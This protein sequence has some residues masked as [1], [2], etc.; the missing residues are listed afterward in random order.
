MMASRT[1]QVG[2]WTDPPG[3]VSSG[4]RGRSYLGLE[5]PSGGGR[6]EERCAF[7]ADHLQVIITSPRA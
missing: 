2:L 7:S 5:A 4:L 3:F 1:L 6:A